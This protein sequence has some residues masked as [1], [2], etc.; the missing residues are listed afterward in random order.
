MTVDE[1]WLELSEIS[2]SA[3]I[4]IEQHQVLH[5]FLKS[6]NNPL[7]SVVV[8]AIESPL[9][10]EAE[11]VLQ[12]ISLLHPTLFEFLSKASN[13]I[14]SRGEEE[15]SEEK[16]EQLFTIG[17][18]PIEPLPLALRVNDQ[19]QEDRKWIIRPINVLNMLEESHIH[20]TCVCSGVS[21]EGN[22]EPLFKQALEGRL[23]KKGCILLLSILNEF[24][25]VKVTDI[26]VADGSV[27]I[28]TNVAYRLKFQTSWQLHIEPH[29]PMI[30][31]EERADSPFDTEW[32]KE[33]PGY[34]LLLQE[35]LEVLRVH[36]TPASPSGILLT[37]CTG[38]GKSRLAS[39]LA[40]NY[41]K[42]EDHVYYLST[43][44]LIFRAATETNLF[45]D[46]ILPQ[47]QQCKL[48]ILDDLHLLERG[49]SD[50]EQ[51]DNERTIVQNSIVEAFDLYH[52]KCRIVGIGQVEAK[53]PT[54]L[55][56]IGRL[57]KSIQMLPP[58]QAQRVIIWEHL[59]FDNCVLTSSTRQNW[60]LALASTT[61]GC[62]VADLVRIYQ[63]ARTRSWAK[64]QHGET[65][66]IQWEE[67]REEARSCIPSQL[68]ELDVAKPAFFEAG[69]SWAEIHRKSWNAFAG[70]T[71]VKQQVFRHVVCPWRQFLRTMDEGTDGSEMAWLEPPA[72]VLFHGPSGCGKTFAVQCLADSLELPMIKVRAADVLDKWLG[73][74]ESLLR[75]LFARARAASPAILFLDE[76]DS[77]ANNRA[78]DDTNDF[79]SRILS[80]LLN[81][82]DGVS[83]SIEKSRILVAACTNRLDALDSALL[84]PGR[85]QDHFFLGA[86]SIEDLVGI[87]NLRLEKIP[88]AF[89]VSIKAIAKEL[90]ARNASGADVEGLCRDVCL[91][92]LGRAG[93]GDEFVISQQEFDLYIEDIGNLTR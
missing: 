17:A 58:T 2:T 80:T 22:E 31:N 87:L 42:V 79:T 68:S 89:D 48:W 47:L 39:C 91:T 65:A 30:N 11:D 84:R 57:E 7:A 66:T 24:A 35:I 49:D 38:V 33:A 3:D 88:L 43:Q 15:H 44:D 70:Y 26:V 18:L 83:S 46:C 81:E 51:R 60:S 69:L 59:L 6:R 54:E 25:V 53:L 72:G 19:K 36:G 64:V 82:M 20:I 56:K 5:I 12:R 92:A 16:T 9:F 90:F 63:N 50:E 8:Q 85:L 13:L 32:D 23:I 75:S 74:S 62:V 93:D 10:S 37:G 21:L 67:L 14:D 29:L 78:E 1:A 34:E 45:R 61:A 73:G 55:T 41:S 86:P 27:P 52:D 77:I 76:I 40:Y 4:Q 28:D 71:T